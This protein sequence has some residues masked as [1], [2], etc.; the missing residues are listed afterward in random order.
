MEKLAELLKAEDGLER[1]AAGRSATRLASGEVRWFRAWRFPGAR[2]VN[3][4]SGILR[5]VCA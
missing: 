3:R 1:D 2:E 4:Y 5:S